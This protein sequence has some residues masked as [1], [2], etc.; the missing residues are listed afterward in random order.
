MWP[1]QSSLWA[2]SLILLGALGASTLFLLLF[3]FRGGSWG[4]YRPPAWASE[5]CSGLGRAWAPPQSRDLPMGQT[6]WAAVWA[7]RERCRGWLRGGPRGHGQCVG[8]TVAMGGEAGRADSSLEISEEA[9]GGDGGSLA[10][11]A[12]VMGRR[13]QCQDAEMAGL[14]DRCGGTK[15]TVEDLQSHK[16]LLHLPKALPHLLL[17]ALPCPHL[18]Q[19]PSPR[20]PGARPQR[21]RSMFE[22]R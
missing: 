14:A 7:F 12:V 15:N 6:E 4:T 13:G 22:G 20:Q 10:G 18:R 17:Q 2:W 5:H 3:P 16:G 9:T 1:S 11:E 21:P 8:T 19:G